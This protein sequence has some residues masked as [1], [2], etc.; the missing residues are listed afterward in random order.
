M[1]IY[2]LECER[3][4]NVKV[5]NLVFYV[6]NKV[7]QAYDLG[8]KELTQVS[9]IETDGIQVLNNQPKQFTWNTFNTSSIDFLLSYNFEEPSVSLICLKKDA[10]KQLKAEQKKFDGI[11]NAVFVSKEKICA[12]S[13]KGE[14]LIYTFDGKSKPVD[15]IKD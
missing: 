13:S 2:K 9:N 5:G 1:Q 8:S 6:K 10:S 14:L 11:K 7:L 15:W 3:F 12:L 4:E